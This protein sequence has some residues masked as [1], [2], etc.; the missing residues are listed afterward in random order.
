MI[1]VERVSK[2][3][4]EQRALDAVSF[5]VPAGES[6]ALWGPNGAGK[7]TVIR[8]LLGVL[9]VEGA[10]RIDGIDPS[11][12]GKR[13]RRRIGFIP[14]EIPLQGDLST[15]E[16]IDFYARL[17]RCPADRGDELMQQ[18]GLAAHAD[19]KVKH[20]SGGLRQ[21]LALAIAL[22]ADPPILLLDE[23]SANLDDASRR[24]FLEV[25]IGLKGDKTIV[26]S[27]HRRSEVLA[28]ADRVLLLDA[29]RLVG[30]GDPLELLTDDEGEGDLLRLARERRRFAKGGEHGAS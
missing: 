19:K 10:I 5:S 27:T 22:L 13:A 4:G 3:F 28:L 7:T 20:L 25:L 1:E 29:G 11:R 16:T 12:R 2:C 30:E 9:A 15:E 23:P 17:R 24:A 18:L 14:Q 6:V 26:F 8:A 21:R